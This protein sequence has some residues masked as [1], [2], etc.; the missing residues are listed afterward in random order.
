MVVAFDL[1]FVVAD[2][3]QASGAVWLPRSRCELDSCAAGRHF[4][5][6]DPVESRHNRQSPCPD[7]VVSDAVVKIDSGVRIRKFERHALLVY[8]CIDSRFKIRPR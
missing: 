5:V 2:F 4:C 8:G 7:P 3:V 6:S 1:L